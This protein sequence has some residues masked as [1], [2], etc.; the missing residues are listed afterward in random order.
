VLGVYQHPENARK[1]L[2]TLRTKGL[3]PS[4]LYQAEKNYYYVYIYYSLN[5]QEVIDEWRRIRQQNQ[6]FGAWI[7]TAISK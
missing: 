2:S 4:I 3:T 7:Y 1:Q 6:Y 5:R